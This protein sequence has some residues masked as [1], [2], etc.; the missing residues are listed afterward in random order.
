MYGA[1]LSVHVPV[2]LSC[3]IA[4]W[5]PV[6]A[7]KGG[8]LHVRVGRY[9]VAAMAFVALSGSFLALMRLVAPEAVKGP[10][11]DADALQRMRASGVFLLYLGVITFVPTF[12]GWRV[13]RTRKDR[14]RIRAPLYVGMLALSALSSLALVA[15]ALFMP[16]ANR[17]LLLGMSP[18]GLVIAVGFLDYVRR[19]ERFRQGW[20]YAHMGAMIGG[21]IA[22]HTA[23]GVFVVSRWLMPGVRGPA[24]LLPWLLPTVVGVPLLILS[25]RRA[26]RRFGDL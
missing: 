26:R 12:F 8:R 7:K 16:G 23:F 19:P 18:I 13:V 2:A 5:I 21:G 15:A 4:Y 10:G 6:F 20:W 14:Q 3:V 24:A 9:F 11:L 25:I 1:V 17:P 22:V